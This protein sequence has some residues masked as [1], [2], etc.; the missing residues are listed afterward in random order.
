MTDQ[1]NAMAEQWFQWQ[2]A[3]LWQS[4]TLIVLVAIID[5]LIRKWAWPQLRYAL[6]LLVLVKLILPPTLSS[7]VS[8]TSP[9]PTWADKVQISPVETE[10]EPLVME[11][12]PSVSYVSEPRGIQAGLGLT[13]SVPVS[14]TSDSAKS[15]LSWKSCAM[16]TW[17]LVALALA[18]GLVIRLKHLH[19]EH[20]MD[21]S[22]QVPDWFQDALE[23][24]ALEIGCMRLPRVVLS[25]RVLCPAVFG[26]FKPVL[27]VPEDQVGHMSPTDARHILLHEL[28]HIKRLDLWS[29]GAY[30]LLLMVYWFNPLLWFMRRHLQNLRELC[31]DATVARTLRE[32]TPAYRETLLE[33]AKNLLA[34]PVDPG[35]GLLGL[36]ENST[37]LV[38]RLQWL[39][40]ET[41]RF[42]R[43]RIATVSLVVTGMVC[44]VLPMATAAKLTSVPIQTVTKAISDKAKV[45]GDVQV[46]LLGICDYPCESKPWRRPDGQVMDTS[47]ITD[48]GWRTPMN[49]TDDQQSVILAFQIGNDDLS[50]V[51]IAWKPPVDSQRST[52]IPTYAN[53]ENRL[54]TKVQYLT[55]NF[56]K[57][58]KVTS[59]KL[60]VALGD[61]QVASGTDG[62]IEGYTN[63][64]LTDRDVHLHKAQSQD[65]KVHIVISH[66]MGSDYDCRIVAMDSEGTKHR[67]VSKSNSGS[68]MR[69][70]K[71][72]FDMALDNIRHFEFQARPYEWIEFQGIALVAHKGQSETRPDVQQAEAMMAPLYGLFESAYNALLDENDTAKTLTIL[73]TAMPQLDVF[74]AKVVGTDLEQGVTMA[75]D[76]VRQMK[77]ALE[78]G[79]VDK[80]KGLM[81]AINA[82]GPHLEEMIR[83]AAKEQK[84]TPAVR[85]SLETPADTPPKTPRVQTQ[86]LVL[87]EPQYEWWLA[88][89]ATQINLAQGKSLTIEWSITEDLYKELEFL[90][91]GVVPEEVDVS[92]NERYQWLANDIPITA[93][94][95]LY[96][97]TWPGTY[98]LMERPNK[99]AKPLTPGN[100]RIVVYGFKGGGG[101]GIGEWRFIL[102][103]NLMCV[104]VAQLKVEP[105]TGDE[106]SLYVSPDRMLEIRNTLND[107][108]TRKDNTVLK[109]ELSVVSKEWLFSDKVISGDTL[110]E[111]YTVRPGDTLSDIGNAHQIPYQCLMKLNDL[112]RA[113]SLQAGLKIKVVNGPFHAKVWSST[114]KMDLYLQDMYVKTYDIAL[115]KPGSDTP[116][117]QWVVMNHGKVRKLLWM[118]P[119]MGL[120]VRPDDPYYPLGEGIMRLKGVGDHAVSRISFGIHG[121]WDKALIGQHV[122]NRTIAMLNSDFLE[123]VDLLK[124]E[125]S[126]IEVME[127]GPVM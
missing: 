79:E 127:E 108:L 58:K 123:V 69:K 4:A 63:D 83:E 102:N 24:A 74:Q 118:D 6:W 110:C 97:K 59:L 20:A 36:F 43:V 48:P 23:K 103:N 77:K 71:A 86:G 111:Y 120:G 60:G 94:K 87:T 113:S 76:M 17:L 78:E 98:A 5:R 9:I 92:E 50:D 49:P 33:T 73:N 67:P 116:T 10:P 109:E 1:I 122:T 16:V 38:T 41:W 65:G 70:C 35:L 25:H 82:A 125:T 32:Q 61:W 11:T 121:I 47:Q 104:A 85:P 45:N 42:R 12:E 112:A 54:L 15:P 7:P 126:I 13:E 29:H 40:K 99:K 81:N 107:R 18:L 51:G 117:G 95:T 37:W 90:A 26:L 2:W 88:K 75:V 62:R 22:Q 57:D 115:G 53:R 96:G 91:V 114:C 21:Q 72:T 100:Y 68:E 55:A 39:E 8:V 93:R 14:E 44:C 119:E 30:M 27:L 84:I 19:K 66:L 31:C 124:E 89:P 105:G 28:A 80:A 34:Q 106:V 56:P 46:E 64:S 3:M 52:Y 101:E